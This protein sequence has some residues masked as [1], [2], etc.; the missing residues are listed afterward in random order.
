MYFMLVCVTILHQTYATLNEKLDRWPLR[1]IYLRLIE[2]SGRVFVL[3]A[4]VI[5]FVVYIPV[6]SNPA[7]GEALMALSIVVATIILVREL[8]GVRSNVY[9]AMRNLTIKCNA[10]DLRVSDLSFVEALA[11]NLFHFKT[12]STSK[13]LI[14]DYL[15]KHGAFPI[16]VRKPLHLKNLSS[17]VSLLEGRF[18]AEKTK[19]AQGRRKV[20]SQSGLRLS[21]IMQ[22]ASSASGA[23]G[24]GV[25]DMETGGSAV[26][27]V[28]D[29]S[30]LRQPRRKGWELFLMHGQLENAEFTEDDFTLVQNEL[31]AASSGTP[32]ALPNGGTGGRSAG[33]EMEMTARTPSSRMASATESSA[34]AALSGDGSGRSNRSDT[35]ES[36]SG[37]GLLSGEK[38]A[39]NNGS[40]RSGSSRGESKSQA[41]AKRAK[42]RAAA[43][44]ID[45]DDEV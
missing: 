44:R 17:L 15:H 19:T 35:S 34:G 45:S 2:V 37:K 9:D 38:T 23:D 29:D 14:S 3:P 11:M 28:I 39:E 40:G 30:G 6:S 22:P 25:T 10:P 31:H 8:F 7:Y 16:K 36:H 18:K 43:P 33:V 5:Y 32:D 26:D 4:V 41:A 42:Q 12:L 20:E 13:L 21:R 1:L 24:L 27:S